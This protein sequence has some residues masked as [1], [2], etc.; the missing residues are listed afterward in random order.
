MAGLTHA[1]VY[2]AAAGLLVVIQ[3]EGT[4]SSPRASSS[5][6]LGEYKGSVGS[7]HQVHHVSFS[8]L[9]GIS[10]VLD[11]RGRLGEV[12]RKVGSACEEFDDNEGGILG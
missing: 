8:C 10:L 7:C 3:C 4:S 12:G 2:V 11:T 1:V 5:P 9:P 6:E